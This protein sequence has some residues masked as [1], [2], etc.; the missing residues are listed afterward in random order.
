[1]NKI[2]DTQLRHMLYWQDRVNCQANGKW[3]FTNHPWLRA[4][5][6]E[7]ARL[8]EVLGWNDSAPPDYELAKVSMRLIWGFMLSASLV[9]VQGKLDDGVEQ[10][11]AGLD[12][13]P[14]EVM[15]LAGRKFS[16]A[17]LKLHDSIDILSAFA[18]LG[19]SF[20]ALFELVMV[21]IGMTW[22]DIYTAMEP[23]QQEQA[24]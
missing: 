10:L 14:N 15:E 23:E 6:I 19:F 5:R 11:R 16:L 20:P 12:F 13:P 22:D 3:L 2:S 8:S 21:G 4:A 9:A 1:M 18:S 7:C 17:N 24:A